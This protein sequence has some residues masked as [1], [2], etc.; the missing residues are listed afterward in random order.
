MYIERKTSKLICSV[1]CRP[2]IRASVNDGQ[3]ISV[4]SVGFWFAFEPFLV[5]WHELYLTL[6]RRSDFENRAPLFVVD[7]AVVSVST[8]T[9]GYGLSISSKFP[10]AR[11]MAEKSGV[12][13]YKT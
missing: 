10:L 8:C 4:E 1:L 7:V 5:F 9:N 11:S 2:T 12:A 6:T 13:I 3:G